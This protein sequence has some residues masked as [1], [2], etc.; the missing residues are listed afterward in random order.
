MKLKSLAFIL[1]IL[2]QLVNFNL[3]NAQKAQILYSIS[4]DDLA[5]EEWKAK[6]IWYPGGAHNEKNQFMLARKSFHLK[7]IP[8][9]ARLLIT[10][11]SHFKLYINGNFISRGPARCN[12]HHQSY[13]VL[14]ISDI[15]VKGEN[16][17]AV[18]VHYHGIMKSYYNDPYPGLLLQTELENKDEL[19][20]IV[21]DQ[22]WKVIRDNAWD[23][24]NEL[25]S[26][27]NGNNFSSCFYFG[28]AQTGW[29]N[30]D[31][32]DQSWSH[33][34]LQ[35]GPSVWPP[36]PDNYEP[37]AVQR[38]WYSL[39]PRDLPPLEEYDLDAY[40]LYEIYEA[41]QFSKYPTWSDSK[42]YNALL[43][44]IQDVQ[45]VLKYSKVEQVQSFLDGES[46]LVVK[47]AY[48]DSKFTKEPAYHTT[49]VFDFEKVLSGYPYIK[50]KGNPGD[51]IDIN[52][53]PYLINGV[54]SPAVLLDNFSDRIFLSDT[55]NYWEAP[56]LRSFRYISVTVRS[57]EAVSIHR[58]GS[59]IEEYPF[60]KKGE[61]DVPEDPFIKKIWEAGENTIRNITTDAYTDNYHERRQYVQTSF[62]AS[63]GNYASFGDP[64]LQRRY[65]VQHAQDQLPNGIIPMWAPWN[66][67]DASKQIPGIFEANHF[68]LMG[69]H[70]Y[71]LYTGDT[72]T[73]RNL[74][75]SAERCAQAINAIQFKDDLLYK[76][77]Y[78]YWID[79]AKLAQGD[80]NFILNALQLL[81]FQ[82]Y[83]ELLHW[84]GYKDR[85][86]KWKKES[87]IIRNELKRFWDEE[88]GLF[89]DN[90]TNGKLDK[91][92]S[93]HSNAL[94]IVAEIANDRQKDMIL[95]KLINNNENR[96]MEE[97]VL[98]NYWPSEAIFGAGLIK[99]GMEFLKNK[100]EHMVNDE[101]GT[102][103][104]YA[105]LYVRNIG[106]RN[107]DAKDEWAGRSWATA[108]A[109]NAFPGIIMSSHVMGVQA[110]AP[111]FE[112]V[113]VTTLNSPY[114]EVKGKMPTPHGIISVDKNKNNLSISI[115]ENINA[116]LTLDLLNKYSVITINNQNYQINEIKDDITLSSGEYNIT[117]N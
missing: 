83:A 115:P 21:S 53:I 43:H 24:R 117:V 31:F 13:D 77:P 74:L 110:T 27:V 2:L 101:I 90:I 48:P 23:P 97:A 70:D 20:Y 72:I 18:R 68:W 15:L 35:T 73:T 109:E 28:R 86:N 10:A 37:Y 36:K 9:T 4:G 82:D 67:Y 1:I 6:W 84:L 89:A 85:G 3:T 65:L 63:L 40:R 5:P 14:D 30:P 44:S 56:N 71:F 12:P 80:Q 88:K 29:Q 16:L 46:P 62:Y 106:N 111:G 66:V 91:N 42:P 50:V 34:V 102:L 75:T 104:E 38:P 52:Y 64:Y 113:R 51:I 33:A 25:V 79:W 55:I 94:A 58:L 103:W 107:S 49:L 47:N 7:E 26:N 76:P 8:E 81:A 17:I 96:T 57:P 112:K 69:L 60:E 41:P 93:E 78:P 59:R 39:V 45:Q 100:Y 19:T 11:T 95:E 87:E 105:N 114:N 116:T 61:I 22:S 32:E 108:Q 98:F 99:E 54:Y 92:F